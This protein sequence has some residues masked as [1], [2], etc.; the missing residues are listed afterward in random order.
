MAYAGYLLKIGDYTLPFKFIKAESYSPYISVAD[1][2]SYRDADGILH[3]NALPD[4][5]TKV[6]WE[7]PAMLD[8]DEFGELMANIYAEFTNTN[9]R[10]AT[11]TMF[12]PELNGY[13]TQDMYMPDIKPTIY[14]HNKKTGKLQYNAIRLAFI[15]YGR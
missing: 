6:E 8:N 11:V 10:R 9:E 4:R 5:S 7:T 12:V 2:D 3:R 1:L 15:G 14:W 13:V